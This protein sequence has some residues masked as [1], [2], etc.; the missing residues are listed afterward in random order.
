MSDET[1]VRDAAAPLSRALTSARWSA[2]A[3]HAPGRRLRHPVVP[4]DLYGGGAGPRACSLLAVF[5]MTSP[6]P[7]SPDAAGS[8][9]ACASDFLGLGTSPGDADELREVV[10]SGDVG[11]R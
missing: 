7:D 3:W 6:P 11:H 4:C 10:D 9:V 8:S 5:R 2:T 1:A